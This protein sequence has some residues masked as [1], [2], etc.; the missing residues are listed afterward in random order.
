[1]AF[2]SRKGPASTL[3]KR[4]KLLSDLR[5][6]SCVLLRL[7]I[8]GD[9]YDTR[10][11]LGQSTKLVLFRCQVQLSASSR[12]ESVP[13]CESRGLLFLTVRG[14]SALSCFGAMVEK[15]RKRKAFS[16]NFPVFKFFRHRFQQGASQNPALKRSIEEDE[17]GRA[18]PYL[19][20]LW[21]QCRQD[22]G[23]MKD[24]WT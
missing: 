12:R 15:L 7:S 20:V 9:K 14:S 24:A 18:A 5:R 16:D 8:A 2:T 3:G 23:R 21:D 6:T 4:R 19:T 1:M 17:R 13:T 22:A 10:D 11:A